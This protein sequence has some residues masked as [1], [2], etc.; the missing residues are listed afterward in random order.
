MKRMIFILLILAFALSLCSCGQTREEPSARLEVNEATSEP[1]SWK[2][3]MTSANGEVK[4]SIHVE[5]CDNIPEAMPVIKAKPM[6]LTSDMLRQASSAI[7]GDAPLYEDGWMLTR[8]ELEQFVASAEQGVMVDRIRED[9][10]DTLSE[11]EIEE[12][13]ARRQAQLDHWREAL[14][15][16]TE[17]M[18]P[19]PSDY[20]F[21]PWEYFSEF[22][23][24]YYEDYPTYFGEPPYGVQADFRAYAEMGGRLYHLWASNLTRD[25]FWNHSLTVFLDEPQGGIAADKA[26]ISSAHLADDSATDDELRQAAERAEAL[27][28]N[29]GFGTWRCEAEIREF[30]TE[31]HTYGIRV[32]G[33]KER[34]GWSQQVRGGLASQSGGGY[35]E[36]F[37]MDCA[38]DGTLIKLELRGLLEEE[39]FKT[40][41][42]ISWEE[43]MN[44]ARAAMNSWTLADQVHGLAFG[45]AQPSGLTREI[46][47]I[48]VGHFR[49]PT[50]QFTYEL[51]PVLCLRGT[52]YLE[53]VP[54]SMNKLNEYGRVFDFLVIDLR[55]GSMIEGDTCG[56]N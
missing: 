11:Q 31:P 37:C 19:I 12:I 26:Y 23:H 33:W 7:F 54:D 24:D 42:L 39:S 46:T 2:E 5:D 52:E 41:P 47:E 45:I 29:M 22:S 10:E 28:L 4:I 16:T 55:D 35:Y 14:A 43:A 9:Y 17:E 21:R 49:K 36:H 48:T 56:Y 3:E 40:T 25:G 1:I 20:L 15:N 38:N 6:T 53:G 13:R 18:I 8:A 50:G 51:I 30:Y 27:L 34:E 32:N 44:A